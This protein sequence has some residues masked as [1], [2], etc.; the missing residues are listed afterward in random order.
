MA[1][2]LNIGLISMVITGAA[3]FIT[4]LITLINAYRKKND[5]LSRGWT[6]SVV[7]AIVFVLFLI[8]LVN[9]L[10]QEAEYGEDFLSG[11]FILVFL[12]FP[13]VLILAITVSIFFL[14]IG[15]NSLKDGY[16]KDK[17]GKRDVLSI[18]LGYLLLALLVVVIA[19]LVMFVYVSFASFSAS[20]KKAY[21]SSSQPSSE[22]VA[23]IKNYLFAKF[24]K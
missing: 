13:L 3:C 5:K 15:I 8:S 11:S 9:I 4:G 16:T 19:S 14:V 10:K 1:T 6:L 22:S 21:N 20:L 24:Y 17:E 12:F 23:I 7:G 2:Y 18:A